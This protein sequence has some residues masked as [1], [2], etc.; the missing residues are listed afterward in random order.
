[1][2]AVVLGSAYINVLN[3]YEVAARG[4]VVNEDIAH[5]RHLVL[6]ESD[7]LKVEDGGEFDT[8]DGRRVRWSAEITSTNIADLFNVAFTCEIPDPNRPEAMR[9]VENF[10]L[11]RPTWSIDPGER[12]KLK[13]QSKTRILELQGRQPGATPTR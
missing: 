13:E 2:A 8:T 11:L 12:G 3:G 5:A 6:A 1:M 4:L 7:R 9:V 10:V